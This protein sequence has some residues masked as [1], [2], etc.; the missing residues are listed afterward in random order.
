[1]HFQH[2]WCCTVLGL[3]TQWGGW[4]F[5]YSFLALQPE[6][7]H[8]QVQS[9]CRCTRRTNRHCIY[10]YVAPYEQTLR[11]RLPW[12]WGRNTRDSC[13]E[14]KQ[15]CSASLPR[16]LSRTC[17]FVKCTCMHYRLHCLLGC[18]SF[19]CSWS[20]HHQVSQSADWAEY[21]HCG[22]WTVSS[23]CVDLLMHELR[24][25]HLQVSVGLDWTVIW[26]IYFTEQNF[27]K[28]SHC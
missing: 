25:V 20:N 5:A 10:S 24:T 18:L 12:Y 23:F 26:T 11:L 9:A 3:D 22:L 17:N 8:M 13:G 27:V 6:G 7:I 28:C 16:F 19:G 21:R 14:G 2:C 4:A 1:M 15:A